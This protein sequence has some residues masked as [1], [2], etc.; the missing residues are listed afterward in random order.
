MLRSASI[1]SMLGLAVS[2]VPS[3]ALA[4]DRTTPCPGTRISNY[5]P[6]VDDGRTIG[7][8]SLWYRSANGGTNCVMTETFIGRQAQTWAA[9]DIQEPG[10]DR[11]DEDRGYFSSFAA[12][13]LAHADSTLI[14]RR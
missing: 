10:A 6:L 8:V 4:T 14:H 5:K 2:L 11:T 7:R 1:A 12:T 3:A 13:E 9:L